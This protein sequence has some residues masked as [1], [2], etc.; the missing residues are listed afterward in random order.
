MAM[1]FEAP[2]HAVRLGVINHRHVIDLAVANRTTDPAIHVRGVIV[3]NVIRRAMN[4]HPLNRL[5]R[6]PTRPHR[7]ELRIIFLHLRMAGHARLRVRH[8]RMR[9]DIHEAVAIAAIHPELRDV[10]IVRERHRLN[11]LISHPRIF[12][13]HVIPRGRRQPAH[14]KDSADRELERQPVTPAWKKIRHK[15]S[16]EATAARQ[17]SPT[18]KRG[19]ETLRMCRIQ[20]LEKLRLN[21]GV[22]GRGETL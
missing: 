7:F 5:S 18:W 10:E 14:N 6:F 9:R 22:Q 8:I 15:R 12:W 19:G 2:R 17:Q 3:K 13:R 4:L 20:K 1:A 11:R 16:A 21:S